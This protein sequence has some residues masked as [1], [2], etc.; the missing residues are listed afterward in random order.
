[1]TGEGQVSV[2]VSDPQEAR[3]YLVVR[4]RLTHV[5]KKRFFGLKDE[6]V[7]FSSCIPDTRVGAAKLYEKLQKEMQKHGVTLDENSV[8]QI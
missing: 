2:K 1:M 5:K 6:V 7:A 3:D 8:K 4:L